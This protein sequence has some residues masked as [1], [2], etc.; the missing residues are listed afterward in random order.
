[1]NSVASKCQYLTDIV[2]TRQ[3]DQLI[4]I[5]IMDSLSDSACATLLV[6]CRHARM[7]SRSR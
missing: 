6:K 2:D 3:L 1:M 7:A 5:L 4:C